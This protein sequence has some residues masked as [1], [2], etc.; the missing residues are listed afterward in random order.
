M[1]HA[2]TPGLRLTERTVVRRE[3]RLPLRGKVLVRSG[4]KVAPHDVVAR[5]ELPGNVQ[6]VNLAARLG[7]DPE[8]V[9]ATLLCGVG[10]PVKRGDP[11]AE[12]RGLF[13][14][15]RRTLVAPT[16]GVI[17]NVS[18]ITGQLIVREP[19]IPVEVQAYVQGTV[20]EVLPGEGVVVEA[21]G[22]LMQGIFGVG[23][24]TW[25]P[26]A[27]GVDAPDAVLT[28]AQVRPEHHGHVLVA[29]AGVSQEALSRA[30]AFG[31]A[32]LVV[33]GI[34][35]V[36]L[37]QLLGRDL[38]VAITGGEDIGLTV[39]V[40]EGFGTLPMSE[41]AW[42]L[43][44]ARRGRLASVSG[45]TQIR[46]GVLRPEVLVPDVEAV[47]EP[48]SADTAPTLD[49]GALVRLI[50]APYFGRIGRVV[51]M[52]AELRRLET[53]ALVRALVVELRPEGRVLVPRANA[54][55]IGG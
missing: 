26:L 2:Y 38:G 50:R 51:E 42:T 45:A 54:E 15:G 27:L 47:T 53:E 33:G 44:A 32:A 41:R 18:T 49:L 24:E 5:T 13:G 28:P 48:A 52:P 55:V 39:V 40:T 7:V 25:G 6:T 9:P 36:D 46:A 1:A 8:R 21:R 10:S 22:A 31:V 20:A 23:G 34:E 14:F 16:D 35:D 11:L 29:G 4:D 30:R 37:R 19:P 43:L 12:A 17:E 3:R